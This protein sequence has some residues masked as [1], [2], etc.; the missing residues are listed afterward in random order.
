MPAPDSPVLLVARFLKANGYDKTLAAFLHETNLPASSVDPKDPAAVLSIEKLLDEKRLFD[1]SLT[2]EKVEILDPKDEFTTPYPTIP[3][4]I[5]PPGT[6]QSNVLFVTVTPSLAPWPHPVLIAT[7]ADRFLRLYTLTGTLLAAHPAL[8]PSAILSVAV[9]RHRWLLTTSM[10]GHL[11]L[12]APTSPTPL[13]ILRPHTKYATKSALTSDGTLLATAAY[14]G[15]I[16][17]HTITYDASPAG[18]P[19]LTPLGTLTLPTPPEALAIIAPPG[20]PTPVLV[21]SRR[22]STSLY[23]HRLARHLPHHAT[24]NL[25]AAAATSWASFH[26]MHVAAHPSD[27]SL[28]AV[29]TSHAPAMKVMLVHAAT[30]AVLT[31]VFVGAPQGAYSSGALAWRPC[32]RGVWVNGDDG[33]VRGVEV[34]SGRVVAAL[35]VCKGGEK[36][37]ALWAGRVAREEWLVT[38]GFDKALKVWRVRG[39]GEAVGDAELDVAE[40]G[41]S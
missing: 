30:G 11:A 1:L 35:R 34:R 2:L 3:R 15:S 14:D 23:H 29:A 28:L 16:A 10:T 7:T 19:T 20:T 39:L 4:L 24:H 25:A 12:S 9:L 27:A 17:A 31:E 40:L 41:R 8:H 26:A 37:R 6:P 32:G 18:A 22:A 21:F 36:V 38:G 13:C 33:V 5:A